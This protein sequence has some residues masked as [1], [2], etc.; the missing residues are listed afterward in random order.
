[1]L[2]INKFHGR[3]ANQLLL[4]ATLRQRAGDDYQCAPWIGQKL[5]GL[6][7]PKIEG[8]GENL[9]DF[10]K[11]SKDYDKVLF[12]HLFVPT[13]S[14]RYRAHRLFDALPGKTTI[15]L[16]LRRGDYGT[17]RRKSARW[18]FVAPT[19]WYK[20]WLEHNDIK[21]AVLVI[22]SDEPDK[23]LDDFSGYDAV[24]PDNTIPEAPYYSDFYALTQCDIVLISNST[25]GFAASMLNRKAV[26][27]FRPKLSERKLIPYDPWYAPVVFKEERYE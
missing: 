10:A 4:Y 25:F 9:K 19:E 5:F 16:H 20:E 3:F 2:R 8:P 17:F 24:V 27:F 6:D 21:N 14:V 22:C 23:V 1:M 18:C 26:A 15:G 12:Q 7:D 11:H 13:Q